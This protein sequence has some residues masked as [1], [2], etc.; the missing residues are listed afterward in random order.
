MEK[1]I[2]ISGCDE[3]YISVLLDMLK[4]I[5]KIAD[6]YAVGICDLGLSENSKKHILDIIPHAEIKIP[7][8]YINLPNKYKTAFAYDIASRPFMKEIFPGYDGYLHVDADLWFQDA[9]AIEDYILAGKKHGVAA[10]YE[11]YSHS[12]PYFKFKDKLKH[13]LLLQELKI[14]SDSVKR[15]KIYFGKESAKKYGTLPVLNGGLVYIKSDNA[16]WDIWQNIMKN[17]NYD[18]VVPKFKL[19][20]QLCL[21]YGLLD[22][23]ISFELLSR[24][25]NWL[26]PFIEGAKDLPLW[27]T[28]KQLLVDHT[29]P[30]QT[31]KVIHMGG[32]NANKTFTLRTTDRDTIKTKITYSAISEMAKQ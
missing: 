30:H 27:D 18:K 7:D 22:N 9:S 20:D 3:N 5:S 31:I 26:I 21:Q 17:L 1:N 25:Y 4:S 23:D 10:V 2:L 29:Y 6:R 12:N 24:H 8:W 28:Q 13:R 32:K 14:H 16:I 11:H 15:F 19:C